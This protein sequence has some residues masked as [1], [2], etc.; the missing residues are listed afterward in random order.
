MRPWLTPSIHSLFIIPIS[1][2]KNPP[3]ANCLILS[4][5]HTSFCNHK[6]IEVCNRC[7]MEKHIY[8]KIWLWYQYYETRSGEFLSISLL[9]RKQY[10]TPASN[11]LGT[12]IWISENWKLWIPSH[13]R[14]GLL[15]STQHLR[16][17]LAEEPLEPRRLLLDAEKLGEGLRNLSLLPGKWSN[18]LYWGTIYVLLCEDGDCLGPEEVIFSHSLREYLPKLKLECR[19]SFVPY[20]FA[21]LN[22]ICFIMFF[23]T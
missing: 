23:L 16:P 6:T 15:Y 1:F 22:Q 2:C 11:M 20:F 7:W 21:T 5:N 17:K 8:G 3:E 9:K 12:I 10:F 13:L 19:P 4:K 18:G 14:A